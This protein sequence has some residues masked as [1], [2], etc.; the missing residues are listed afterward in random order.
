MN[1]QI[2]DVL[3]GVII[4]FPSHARQEISADGEE[5]D[6][7]LHGS[8]FYN[9]PGR[10]YTKVTSDFDHFHSV[11]SEFFIPLNTIIGGASRDLALECLSYQSILFKNKLRPIVD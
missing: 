11:T 4:C 8:F 3:D 5:D 1:E 10:F 6:I 7:G 2:S 9:Q